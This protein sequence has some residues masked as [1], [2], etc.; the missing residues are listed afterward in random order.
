[1]MVAVCRGRQALVQVR[2]CAVGVCVPAHV[3]ELQRCLNAFVKDEFKK[4][5]NN[6]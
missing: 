2:S 1:M 3:P 5:N 4:Q 6:M